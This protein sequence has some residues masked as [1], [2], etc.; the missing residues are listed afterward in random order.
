MEPMFNLIDEAWIP[1]IRLDGRAESLSLRDILIQAH[2]IRE[3]YTD[4]PLT[5]AAL[6][7]LS[8]AIL[9][10]CFGPADRQVWVGLWKAE[11]WNEARLEEYLAEH[12]SRFYLFAEKHPFYQVAEFPPGAAREKHP[13]TQLSPELSSGNNI[14]LFDHSF[15]L[16]PEPVPAAEA[17]RRLI[18][19]EAFNIGFGISHKEGNTTYSFRDAP[20]A[21][22]ACFLV[23][24][25]TLFQTL[26]LSMRQYP[27]THSRLPDD[28]E[29][30][31]PAWEMDDPYT[32]YRDVPFGYLDYLTWQSLRIQLVRDDESSLEVCGVRRI[33]GLGMNKESVLGPLKSYREDRQ[34]KPIVRGL[35]EKRALWRD[36]AALFELTAGENRLG[37][38]ES[39]EMLSR[40]AA[41]YKVLPRKQR[42]RYLAFGLATE[43]GKARNVAL[44]RYERMPLP[45]NYLTD[46]EAVARLRDALRLAE[47]VGWRLEQA[48]DWLVWLWLKPGE[49]RTFIKWQDSTDYK[50]RNKDQSFVALQNR[51]P[52]A[53]HYWWRLE[54]LFKRIMEGLAGEQFEEARLEWRVILR[55]AAGDAFQE[56][57]VKLDPT[58]QTLKA[59]AKAEAEL[60]LSVN[61]TLKVDEGGGNEKESTH[62]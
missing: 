33:Q 10:R 21:R 48:R 12:H 17:T 42:F 49:D 47:T 56:L 2:E 54:E 11:K 20:C 1:C 30:D 57:T 44:W 37:T 7:R 51:L 14:T 35:N 15:D 25:D 53:I 28:I 55:Q 31:R 50:L 8:L 29:K 16:T 22:G 18:T 34:G 59:I 36:S 52:V 60:T 41:R 27:D 43:E 6:H 58:P 45:L 23:Q 3:I 5:V 32:P 9:H 24:G 46:E 13:V 40:V 19:L 4:S 61:L 62:G 38:P 39:F 26:L